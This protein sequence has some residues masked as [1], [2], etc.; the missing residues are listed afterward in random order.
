L[1]LGKSLTGTPEHPPDNVPTISVDAATALRQQAAREYDQAVRT[2][3]ALSH[4]I[5]ENFAQPAA[6][7]T[8]DA[9]F[10]LP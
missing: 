9:N 10:I 4:S 8:G 3:I 7:E 2:L 1:S 5:T 6:F